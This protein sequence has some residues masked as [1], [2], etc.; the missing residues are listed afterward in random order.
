ME[1][2]CNKTKQRTDEE[3]KKIIARLHKINGQINGV[4]KMINDKQNKIVELNDSIK[5]KKSKLNQL[6]V[7][8][9]DLLKQEKKYKSKIYLLKIEIE[10]NQKEENEIILNYENNTKGLNEVNKLII[11]KQKIIED[12][13]KRICAFFNDANKLDI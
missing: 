8:K 2:C 1:N 9:N 10:K 7:N 3:K 12:K 6:N 4:E 5:N 11:K 13:R